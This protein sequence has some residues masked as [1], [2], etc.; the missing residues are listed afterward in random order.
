MVH[1]ILLIQSSTFFEGEENG[2]NVPEIVECPEIKEWF[3][4]SPLNFTESDTKN[5]PEKVLRLFEDASLC[6]FK[7]SGLSMYK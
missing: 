1:S 3:N 6:F 4:K 5:T 7:S 2:H